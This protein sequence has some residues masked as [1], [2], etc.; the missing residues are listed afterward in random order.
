MASQD[1]DIVVI[2]GGNAGLSAAIVAAEA[3]ARVCVLEAAPQT[4]RGGH[5]RHPPTLRAMHDAPTDR[6]TSPH[7]A[8]AYSGPP[9]PGA[10]GQ[11]H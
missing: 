6:L 7:E 11:T 8:A 5:S 10:E 4:P 1:F 3:G 9:L 2:G